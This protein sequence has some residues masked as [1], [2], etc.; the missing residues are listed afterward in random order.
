MKK[1]K[2]WTVLAAMSLL[3][4]SLTG[5]QSKNAA[6]EIMR[7]NEMSSSAVSDS[8]TSSSKEESSSLLSPLLADEPSQVLD[9]VVINTNINNAVEKRAA[10]SC[11]VGG[12]YGFTVSGFDMVY[13]NEELKNCF[14]KLQTICNEAYFPMSFSYKNINTG[15]YVGYQQYNTFMTCSCVKAPYVKSILE[16]G[17]DL[18]KKIALNEKWA[19]D[20]G[21]LSGKDY[22]TEYTAKELIEYTIL[23]S[24]NT[25]YQL[26]C[27]NFGT[28]HFNSTQYSLGSNYTLGYNGE[29]IFSYCTSDDMMKD[30]EDIYQFAEKNENGKWLVDLMCNAKLNIQIGQALGKKYPVA[31]KYGTDYL[32]SAF[33]DCAIVYADSPFVLCIFTTQIPETE[34]S[35]RVFKDIALVCDD[36]N[37]LIAE[38]IP[39]EEHDAHEADNETHPANNA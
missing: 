20:D 7:K 34:E 21:T 28:E 4:A 17:I 3:C 15:A 6:A 22:G 23:E 8:E 11:N 31:Q 1:M 5:C 39:E 32:E 9:E 29:W 18:D 38:D 26:L 36:I 12:G 14:D 16:D 25:A 33:N 27:R 19:G 35:C 10:E 2:F 13:S 30:Y 24:D 37:S